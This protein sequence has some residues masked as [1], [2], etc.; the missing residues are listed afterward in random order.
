MTKTFQC[1]LIQRHPATFGRVFEIFVVVWA[2]LLCFY[3]PLTLGTERVVG[4]EPNIFATILSPFRGTLLAHPMLE[5]GL[6]IGMWTFGVLWLCQRCLPISPWLCAAFFTFA[7]AVRLENMGKTIH[8]SHL[9]ALMLWILAWWRQTTL[10]EFR[11]AKAQGTPW[12]GLYYPE[13]VFQ[14]CLLGVCFFYGWAGWSKLAESGL[15]WPNGISMQ[16]WT[17]LWGNP[18]F[19]ATQWILDSR[20]LAIVLQA[21]SIVFEVFAPLAILPRCRFWIGLGLVAM[22]LGII[23]VFGW[24]F[25]GN[26]IF[27]ALLMFP[28]RSWLEE[29]RLNL[30]LFLNPCTPKPGALT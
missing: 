9:S 19:F 2:A 29:G 7:W 15:D 23:T 25:H 24:G 1:W 11:L 18:H 10:S 12:S 5:L 21:M 13:W 8:V 20:P 17:R 4:T 30:T 3:L 6:V 16:I 26:M 27:I 22:H 28:F 14:S